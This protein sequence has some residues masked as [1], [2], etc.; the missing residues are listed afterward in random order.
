MYLFICSRRSSK[1]HSLAALTLPD[2]HCLRH[3]HCPTCTRSRHSHCP[4]C[5]ARGIHTARHALV[6]GTHFARHAL[7]AALTVPD[8]HSLA[9]LTLPD[10][11]FLPFTLPKMHSPVALTLLDIHCSQHSHCLTCTRLWHSHC[12]TTSDMLP[13]P[14]HPFR[15]HLRWCC[16]LRKL[17]SYAYVWQKAGHRAR[18]R[19]S[20]SCRM[21]GRCRTVLMLGRCRTVRGSSKCLR[22]RRHCRIGSLRLAMSD[23]QEQDCCFYWYRRN[24]SRLVRM[25]CRWRSRSRVRMARHSLG[26]TIPRVGARVVEGHASLFL[27]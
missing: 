6:R 23:H 26:T 15:P 10:M 21:S 4:T 18:L 1:M 22:T 27:A 12:L 9:A 7:L 5:T 14:D 25:R 17:S 8:M 24:P 13:S 11:H 3:S 2:M 19:S 16:R 20:I